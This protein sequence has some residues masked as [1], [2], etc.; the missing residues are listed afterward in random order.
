[1]FFRNLSRSSSRNFSNFLEISFWISPGIP[2]KNSSKYAISEDLLHRVSKIPSEIYRMV[3]RSCFRNFC[4]NFSTSFFRYY[5]IRNREH[6][7]WTRWCLIWWA[8]AVTEGGKQQSRTVYRGVFLLVLWYPNCNVIKNC[9]VEEFLSLFFPKNFKGFLKE[10][11]QKILKKFLHQSSGYF[12][13]ESFSNVLR[14]FFQEFK[15]NFF[16]K[17]L[18]W[19]LQKC[20]KDLFKWDFKYY[21]YITLNISEKLHP[22]DFL[23]RCYQGFLL[24]DSPYE[25]I[26]NPSND[27]FS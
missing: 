26:R 2:S 20:L 7:K 19:F 11:Q 5:S 4:W 3:S 9:D 12:S 27:S 6:D 14:F 24:T 23:Q 10:I 25:S 15:L 18:Q 1:M 17:F 16:E 21:L 13:E 8:L 22:S